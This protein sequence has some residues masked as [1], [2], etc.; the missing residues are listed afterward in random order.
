[1]IGTAPS[2]CLPLLQAA[3]GEPSTG[4]GGGGC[5][6]AGSGGPSV[7]ARAVGGM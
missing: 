5:L 6:G 2:S 1:V 3:L 4:G 7:R